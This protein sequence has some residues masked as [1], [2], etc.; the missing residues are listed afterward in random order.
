M[1]FVS[2]NE[3]RARILIVED[4]FI[5][6]LGIERSL[7][8]LGYSVLDTVP[9]G[10]EAVDKAIAE[11]PDLVLMDI[12]LQG[13]IDGLDSAR[14]IRLRTDIP[15]IFLTAYAD[16]DSLKRARET[17]S[18]GFIVKP[19]QDFTLKSAIDTALYKHRAERKLRRSEQWLIVQNR[20]ASVFLTVPD[21]E[22]YGKVLQIILGAMAST[23]GFFGYIDENGSFLVPSL[24]YDIWDRCAVSGKAAAFTTEQWRGLWG[25]ALRE[26]K[27][28]FSTGPFSLPKG[29]LTIDSFLTVPIVYRGEVIGLLGVANKEEG[30]S[31]DDMKF[32]E[33][34]ADNI[35]PILQARLERDRQDKERRRAEEASRASERLLRS[36]IDTIPDLF[37][38][39]DRD[40]RIVFSNWHGG[41]D[42]VPMELRNTMPF[43]HDAYYRTE[44]V[45]EDCPAKEVFL[46]GQ[47][48]VVEKYNP[49]I[50]YVE[51]RAFPIFDVSGNVSMVTQHVRRI[52]RGKPAD[53]DMSQQE[54]MP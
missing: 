19:F 37:K 23:Y 15:I 39:I 13:E 9:S 52:D 45:C 44:E 1:S 21:E 11:Q 20:I 8:A 33:A 26:G 41:Y 32:L 51:I 28:F 34:I 36:A 10:E 17:E 53:E 40:Y 7:N 25:R 29:H 22:M 14:R 5:I 2:S 47:P 49:R 6:A 42:Y 4:E 18:Y 46:T 27:S 31:P 3:E 35:S 54:D 43:C 50:G 12:N 24:T 30:Y 16:N 38:V 48:V